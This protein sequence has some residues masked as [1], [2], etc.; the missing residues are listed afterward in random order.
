MGGGREKP[1]LS[2]CL[3]PLPTPGVLRTASSCH[4]SE[5]VFAPWLLVLLRLLLR[6]LVSLLTSCLPLWSAS[7]LPPPY[8]CSRSSKASSWTLRGTRG[9]LPW[10]TEIEGFAFLLSEGAGLPHL[11]QRWTKKTFGGVVRCVHH[12]CLLTVAQA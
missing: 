9:G 8:C 11:F 1:G 5:G 2:G 10:K 12:L 6:L 7:P 4:F 3:L